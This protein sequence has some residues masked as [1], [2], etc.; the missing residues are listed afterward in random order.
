MDGSPVERP[1]RQPSANEDAYFAEYGTCPDHN[2]G[3]RH[4][5]AGTS[6]TTGKAYNAFWACPERGCKEKPTQ[7][8]TEMAQVAA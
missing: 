7:K 1:T 4:I 3:W 8:W 2:A 6:K 5:P